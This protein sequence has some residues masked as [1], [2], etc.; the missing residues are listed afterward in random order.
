MQALSCPDADAGAGLVIPATENPDHGFFG[1]WAKLG[2][3]TRGTYGWDRLFQTVRVVAP[4]MPDT[5][6]RQRL[7]SPAGR[8]AC[9]SIVGRPPAE[10]RTDAAWRHAAVVVIRWGTSAW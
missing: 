3:R 5:E 10:Q 4:E 7:D 6:I 9:D 8:H 2:Y 1:Q